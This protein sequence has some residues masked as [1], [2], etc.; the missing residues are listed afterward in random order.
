MSQSGIRLLFMASVLFL[1]GSPWLRSHPETLTIIVE[2]KFQQ[3]GS[4]QGEVFF[5]SES[6]FM[7]LPEHFLPPEEA[8]YLTQIY[9]DE[10]IDINRARRIFQESFFA[11]MAFLFDEGPGDYKT[12]YGLDPQFDYDPS[13][14]ES[15]WGRVLVKGQ[16]PKDAKTFRFQCPPEFYPL[17]INITHPRSSTLFS[18]VL[19]PGMTR[20]PHTFTLAPEA[21]SPDHSPPGNHRF[22]EFFKQGAAHIVSGNLD[23]LLLALTILLL[24]P[25]WRPALTQLTIL[26]FAEIL[27]LTLLFLGCP[28]PPLPIVTIALT[29][30]I[31][32]LAIDN[33][34]SSRIRPWRYPLLL[35]FSLLHT[36]SLTTAFQAQKLS[37]PPL[38]IAIAGY[39][40]GLFAGQSAIILLGTLILARSPYPRR[41]LTIPPSALTAA[42]AIW[43]TVQGIL[44]TYAR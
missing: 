6:L 23:H 8:K 37:G 5:D 38:Y 3:D 19:T 17:T 2:V 27:A 28:A 35:L 14:Q 22:G 33:L 9:Q 40:L 20:T 34:F 24:L 10:T 15:F 36:A 39:D 26:L 44:N 42:I 12:E 18:D 4:W 43:W 29:L 32:V 16:V 41:Y 7:N 30:L 1:I 13:L 31:A 25:A 11:R 21:S